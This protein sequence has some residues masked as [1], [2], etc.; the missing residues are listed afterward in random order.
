MQDKNLFS[1]LSLRTMFSFKQFVHPKVCK[2]Y[3]REAFSLSLLTR[4]IP[5]GVLYH[6]GSCERNTS[7]SIQLMHLTLPLATWGLYRYNLTL[8]FVVQP[9]SRNQQWPFPTK[10]LSSLPIAMTTEGERSSPPSEDL[11]DA[12]G[13][14][15][16]QREQIHWMSDNIYHFQGLMFPLTQFI[17]WETSILNYYIR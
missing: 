8:M 4:F 12:S 10:N 15:V 16:K 2:L 17:Y 14:V 7:Q 3:A 6:L 13:I 1:F 5:D 11:E 9:T